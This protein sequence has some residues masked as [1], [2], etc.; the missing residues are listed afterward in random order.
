[1][2]YIW[3]IAVSGEA[4]FKMDHTGLT[5]AGFIQANVARGLIESMPNVEKGLSQRFHWLI[6]K[7]N[8]VKFADLQSADKGF[9]DAIGMYACI[10]YIHKCKCSIYHCFMQ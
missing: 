3:C 6:P 10:Y 8:P 4:N 2:Y 1:M 9:S 7:P 5:V